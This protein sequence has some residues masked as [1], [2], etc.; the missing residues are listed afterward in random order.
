[1][2]WL[3]RYYAAK[4]RGAVALHRHQIHGTAG[5]HAQARVHLQTAAS[6]WSRYAELWSSQYDGQVLTRMGLTRVDIAAIQT[7]V[8]RDVPP[9]LG[10]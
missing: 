5:E 1:M 8:D 2:A 10:R 3:G 6:H 7:F 4:I 9:P